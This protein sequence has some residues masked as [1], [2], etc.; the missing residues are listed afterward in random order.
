MTK[1]FFFI[2]PFIF[3]RVIWSPHALQSTYH[4]INV[5]MQEKN[6]YLKVLA[7]EEQ[8]AISGGIM[9]RIPQKLDVVAF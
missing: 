4:Q 9:V 8:I 7:V 1:F 2:L 6:V 3:H 5:P